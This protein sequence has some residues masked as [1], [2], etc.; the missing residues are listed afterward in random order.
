MK[1]KLLLRSCALLACV[2]AATVSAPAQTVN[3]TLVSVTP[4]VSVQ[5]HAGTAN[6]NVAAGLLN[7]R[8]DSVTPTPLLPFPMNLSL[9]C[10]ELAQNVRLNEPNSALRNFTIQNAAQAANNGPASGLG[11]NIPTTGIGS[12]RARNLEI[13]YAQVF[14]QT[15]NPAA[16]SSDGKAAFQLAVWELSHDTDFSLAA[17]SVNPHFW[18]TAPASAAIRGQAQ[19][20]VTAV[21]NLHSDA[22]AARMALSVLHSDTVQD[23]LLP[24]AAAFTPIPEA[25]AYAAIIGAFILGG[26][27]RNRFKNNRPKTA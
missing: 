11:A 25:Q 27:L 12:D 7:F 24:S 22:N 2:I 23:F 6:F 5:G 9:F 19:T 14:G 13:L 4:V 1:T 26:V 20:W 8:V 15:Y 3:M 21:A 18:V 17:T 16:L 10:T